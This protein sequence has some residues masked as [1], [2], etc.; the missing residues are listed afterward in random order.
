[1][2][3]PITGRQEL[4]RLPLQRRPVAEPGTTLVFVTRRG[5][6]VASPD[7]FTSGEVW[8]R[9]YRAA[10]T[11]DI[12][13][14]GAA[15]T[16]RLPAKGDALHFDA[17]VTYNWAVHDAA[18][19][20]RDEVTDAAGTC[21]EYLIKEMR[22]LCRR[23]DP[24][25]GDPAEQAERLI[26]MELGQTTVRLANGLSVTALHAALSLDPEQADIAKELLIGTLVQKR[27][28]MAARR[29]DGVENIRQ[30]GELRRRR[31]R[32]EFYEDLTGDKLIANV[33]AEDPTQA[34]EV[35]RL[36]TSMEQQKRSEAIKAMQVIIDGG[37]LQIG[38]LD[39]AISAVV[40]QFTA[41]VSDVNTTIADGSRQITAPTA[42]DTGTGGAS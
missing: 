26:D 39:P 9:G 24:V 28:E 22:R 34:T 8:W 36:M 2:T 6:L 7:A 15:F 17:S 10:Y 21:R 33:L 1:L 13:P 38:D 40:S 20:V 42:E 3:N 29:D 14:H 31:A 4:S 19:V 30:D 5:E 16:C 23:V 27:D 12:K 32:I 18:T 41:L 35:A 37:H 25:N 11:V